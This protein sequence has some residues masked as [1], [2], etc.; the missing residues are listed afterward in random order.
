MD[1]C[2]PGRLLRGRCARRG[3]IALV[4]ALRPDGVGRARWLSEALDGRGV[5]GRGLGRCHLRLHVVGLRSRLAV[6]ALAVGNRRL[7]VVGRRLGVVGLGVGGRRRVA[8]RLRVGGRGCGRLRVV[9]L[10][11]WRPLHRRL[12]AGGVAVARRRKVE[13]GVG[14]PQA[15]RSGRID[16]GLFCERQLLRGRVTGFG[17]DRN[18]GVVAVIRRACIG[19]GHCHLWLAGALLRQRYPVADGNDAFGVVCPAGRGSDLA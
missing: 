6:A 8:R 19:V 5:V 3:G 18:G 1:H 13:P 17:N 4:D 11:G 7:G 15:A 14:R 10:R 12:R 2:G 9:H 16:E